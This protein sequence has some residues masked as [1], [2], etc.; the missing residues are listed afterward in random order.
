MTAHRVKIFG[1]AWSQSTGI[2]QVLALRIEDRAL[3]KTREHGG[4]SSSLSAWVYRRL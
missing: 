1:S 4:P 2:K 3:K